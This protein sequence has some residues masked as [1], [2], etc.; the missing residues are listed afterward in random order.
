MLFRSDDSSMDYT[1]TDKGK[2]VAYDIIDPAAQ[3]ISQEHKIVRQ[4]SVVQP[5]P[6]NPT[7]QTIQV[8]E[9]ALEG[10]TVYEKSE[11]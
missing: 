10:V 2:E 8:L 9:E 5:S 1:T 11:E 6:I 3:Q 7:T 4:G